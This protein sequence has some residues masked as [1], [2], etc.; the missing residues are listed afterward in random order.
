MR[1]RAV[2]NNQSLA[3]RVKRQLQ[4]SSITK[5]PIS[6]SVPDTTSY[7]RLIQ[8][9]PEP[10]FVHDGNTIFFTNQ[11]GLKLLG[12]TE[13][14]MQRDPS[15]S[16]FLHPDYIEFSVDR[17]KK[18]MNTDEPNEFAHFKVIDVS[19]EIIDVE[20]SSTRIR[21]YLGKGTVA[22]SVFRDI[23]ERKKEEEALIQSE[24][25]SVVGQMAAGIAHEIRNP[26]TSLIG[27][28]KFL[29]TRINNYHEYFDIMLVE[30]DRI[31]TIVQEFM[32]LAKPQANQF[33][34]HDLIKTIQSVLT[35]LETQAIMNNVQLVANYDTAAAELLCEENQL[36]QVFVN[37]I[38]NA[39]ESMPQGGIVSIDLTSG[40]LDEITV[41]I[42]D[43]GIGIPENQLSMLGG[44]F[45]TTKASG[46]GLGL[47]ICYRIIEGHQG[48]M[49]ISSEPG[50][51]TTVTIGLRK[52]DVI[53]S[54]E[55]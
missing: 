53:H 19:G 22:Q 43:Q 5:E 6:E 7:K 15:I 29:K 44:P 42:A 27:F 45:F 17:I 24:K 11:A 12:T 39:I 28:S 32:A 23:R 4:L 20:A 10:I 33:R 3:V 38:K 18:V 13:A 47:M 37:V 46:T 48:R 40:E 54:A 1:R 2:Y 34:R 41:S 16:R 51:G 8:Y 35:L 36:K 21:N 49:D 30:L 25:L 50:Q 52:M 26:L 9:L 14:D 31:N 55:G